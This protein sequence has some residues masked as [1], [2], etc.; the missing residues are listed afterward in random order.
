MSRILVAGIGNIF[1][2]DDGFGVAVAEELR[3]RALPSAVTVADFGIRGLDL[4]YALLDGWAAAILVDAAPRGEPPGTLSVI[5]PDMPQVS[6]DEPEDLL[7]SPHA[8]EP[9][10]VLRLAALLGA[11]WR[12]VL[13]VACEPLRLVH[14]REGEI[15]LS[16]PV[17]A[18][19]PP[20]ADLVA[21]LARELMEE[22]RD[23]IDEQEVA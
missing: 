5:E 10:K 17:R 13:L 2:G 23:E 12:R 20:A 8:M 18:A 11:S 15:G 16:P 6:A 19:V 3:G 7:L 22:I 4:V 21:R 9:H 14:D 1:D